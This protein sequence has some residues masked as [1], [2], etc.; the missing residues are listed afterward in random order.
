MIN[1]AAPQTK[2]GYEAAAYCELLKLI[3]SISNILNA[4]VVIIVQKRLLGLVGGRTKRF[5]FQFR[6]LK[7]YFI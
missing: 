7:C 1:L 4:Q 2:S 5:R 6:F 3:L